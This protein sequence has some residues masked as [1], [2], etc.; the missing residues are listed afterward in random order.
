MLDYGEIPNVSKNCRC[1]TVGSRSLKSRVGRKN[2]I[3]EIEFGTMW[4]SDVLG[5]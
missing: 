1:C 4:K 2:Q 5:P 3:S